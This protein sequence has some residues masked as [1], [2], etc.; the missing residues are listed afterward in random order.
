M[1]ERHTERLLAARL[2]E[3]QSRHRLPSVCAGLVRRGT[4]IWSGGR[5]SI[6]GTSGPTSDAEV[7]YRAGSITKTFIAVAVLRLRDEG[8]LDLSDPIGRYLAA[9]AASELTIGELLAHTSGLRAETPGPWWERTPGGALRGIEEALG[10]D[11]GRLRPGARHHYSNVGYALLGK[12]I[13]ER[14]G[15]PWYEVISQQLLA[16]LGMNRTTRRPEAPHAAGFAVHPHADLLLPE[17][18]YDA[19]FM[20]PA[21]QLWTTVADLSSLAG[22]LAGPGNG[23][24]DPGTLAEMRVLHGVNDVPGRPWTSG[25]GLGLQL[26]NDAGHRSYGHT[27]SMPGFFAMLQID[28]ASGDAAIA[29]ANSTAGFGYGFTAD[30][31]QILADQEPLLRREWSPV[32]VAPD[33]AG[34]LGTWYRGPVP[35]LVGVSAGVLEFRVAGAAAPPFRFSRGH[36]GTWTG[37]DDYYE[38]EP[39]TPVTGPDGRVVAL[40]LASHTYTRAP[41][42]PA[43]PVPGGVDPGGWLPAAAQT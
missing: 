14:A 34:L 1:I 16:P 38:G 3:E 22:F 17:P 30:L 24:I 21:G 19:G 36:D 12:L 28:S 6:G 33:V 18:E 23:L 2:A 8:S 10:E 15:A 32:N 41:Y 27:G 29:M 42:D 5:G 31:L 26:W 25:Y 39:L 4:L 13:E 7:Q 43:A 37:L 35:F 20:A 40:D 9:P 11:P